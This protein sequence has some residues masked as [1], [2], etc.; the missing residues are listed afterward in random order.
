[1]SGYRYFDRVSAFFGILYGGFANIPALRVKP[2]RAVL[3][4]Q[5]YF[6]GIEA[7]NKTVIMGV[8]IGGMLIIHIV[9]L[10]GA[11]GS[12][13]TG[14]IIVWLVVR[15]LGPLFTAMIV[16][17]RSV[18]A[19]S[20]ELGAMSVTGEIESLKIMGVDPDCYLVMPRILA[21][22]S[23][24]VALTFYFEFSALVGGNLLATLMLD[25]PFEEF[26]S[27]VLASLTLG[28]LLV[29]LIKSFCFGLAIATMA[30]LHGMKVGASLTKIP[31][32]ITKATSQG[33]F[34]VLLI[35]SLM[36][37]LIP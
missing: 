3:Y 1:M 33:L 9:D 12:A 13:L 29:S 20:A 25:V 27:G 21:V 28:E 26:L 37:F 36:A 4:R 31:Q 19:I 5:I 11:S 7:M 23:V 16:I 34:L 6:I 30:C 8:L 17:A 24:S 10:V 22:V 35:D 14:K 15:E 18:T 2:I 32:A